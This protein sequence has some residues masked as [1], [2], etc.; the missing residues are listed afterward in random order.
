MIDNCE[1]TGE[2]K[3]LW[4]GCEY[5]DSR[6]I[7]RQRCWIESQ[8]ESEHAT[9]VK[10]QSESEHAISIDELSVRYTLV[11]LMKTLVQFCGE[12]ASSI[13]CLEHWICSS[14]N[15]FPQYLN[16][17]KSF[18]KARWPIEVSDWLMNTL[19]LLIDEL[20]SSSQ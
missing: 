19:V 13:S 7:V 17:M 4:C 5:A 3:L 10:S 18:V 2:Y 14:S 11:R 6:G 8:S 16:W 12:H 20:A 15:S 1:N 9:S